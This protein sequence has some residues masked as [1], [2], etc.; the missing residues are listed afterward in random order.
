MVKRREK[1]ASFFLD[2]DKPAFPLLSFPRLLSL[3]LP[4]ESGSW[5][6]RAPGDVLPGRGI[7]RAKGTHLRVKAPPAFSP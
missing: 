7:L 4:W 2:P 5:E 1:T 6:A 3:P